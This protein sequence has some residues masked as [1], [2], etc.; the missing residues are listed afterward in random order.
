MRS[1]ENIVSVW[2]IIK[3][4]I[5]GS[6]KFNWVFGSWATTTLRILH[7]NLALKFYKGQ[8]WEKQLQFNDHLEILKLLN[9]IEEQADPFGKY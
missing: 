5:C 2:K 8:R 3:F 1:T 6:A 4:P 9:T 7:K